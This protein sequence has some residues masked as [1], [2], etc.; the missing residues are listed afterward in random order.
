[1]N[2]QWFFYPNIPKSQSSFSVLHKTWVSTVTAIAYGLYQFLSKLGF[3]FFVAKKKLTTINLESK[4][5]FYTPTCSSSFR[6]LGQESRD[7]N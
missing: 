7:T 5:L 6:K 2:T 4:G 3:P 1:M